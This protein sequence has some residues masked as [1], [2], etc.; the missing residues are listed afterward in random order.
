MIF[1]I[2]EILFEIFDSFDFFIKVATNHNNF[3]FL[4]VKVRNREIKFTIEV[5][6]YRFS[7][8]YYA[9]CFFKNSD[10]TFDMCFTEIYFYEFQWEFQMAATWAQKN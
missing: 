1:E 4:A 3:I 10:L 9:T 7:R 6:D 2:F 5:L 8:N